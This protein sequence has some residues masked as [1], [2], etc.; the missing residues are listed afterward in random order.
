M[1]TQCLNHHHLMKSKFERNVCL[2][3]ILNTPDDSDIGYFI[4]VDL[5]YAYDMRQK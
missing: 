5:R 4:E 3:T 2:E 1:V